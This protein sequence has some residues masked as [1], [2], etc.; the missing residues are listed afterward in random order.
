M[1]DFQFNVFD[2]VNENA[3]DNDDFL[4]DFCERPDVC[5]DVIFHD[6]PKIPDDSFLLL[7][8]IVT[9]LVIRI[10]MLFSAVSAFSER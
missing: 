6:R 1:V 10:G 8:M 4:G 7:I 5:L 2:L 3:E 9:V